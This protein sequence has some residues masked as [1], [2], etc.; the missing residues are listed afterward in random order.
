MQNHN[1]FNASLRRLLDTV[2]RVYKGLSVCKF[3]DK[4]P[5][6]WTSPLVK[7]YLRLPGVTNIENSL[8][9]PK[10][11]EDDWT[12]RFLN[13]LE[14]SYR[15]VP[16][17]HVHVVSAR[18]STVQDFLGTC[19][20]CRSSIH[21]SLTCDTLC[22]RHRSNTYQDRTGNSARSALFNRTHRSCLENTCLSSVCRSKRPHS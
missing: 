7:L 15:D 3:D 6:L 18:V 13:S 4:D 8:H 14:Q 17:E 22:S 5:D 2:A 12:E 20:T 1:R 11:L 9:M 19:K 10:A 16:E 21:I